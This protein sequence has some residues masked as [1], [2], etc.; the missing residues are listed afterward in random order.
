[1]NNKLV[2]VSEE[3]TDVSDQTTEIIGKIA[4][5]EEPT[6]QDADQV[7][8]ELSEVSSAEP[9]ELAEETTRDIAEK[10]VVDV[11][12]QMA[13]VVTTEPVEDVEQPVDVTEEPPAD[14]TE[15]PALDAVEERSDA[16]EESKIIEEIC[17][18]IVSSEESEAFFD[19]MEE[20]V[21][22]EYH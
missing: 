12:E 17:Q 9:T 21:T 19:V 1:M 7:P 16:T 20:G 8:A 10:L 11:T 18:E 14:I 6:A 4:T 13:A 3:P 22:E 15:E 5:V 2:E